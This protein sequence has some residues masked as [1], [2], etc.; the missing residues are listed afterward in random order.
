[1]VIVE[2]G[3]NRLVRYDPKTKTLKAFLNLENKTGKL[4]VDGITLA[5]EGNKPA[6]III[7]DSPNG[8]LLRASLD[9][10]TVT[11]I[12]HGFVRPTGVYVETDGSLLVVDEDGGTLSQL[13]TDGKIELIAHLPT[14]DDV[15]ENSAGDLFVNTLGDGAIH[16][17]KAGTKRDEILI[18][19]LSSPQGLILDADGNL[20]VTDPG[21][22]QLVKIVI[23]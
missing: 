6:G 4:G 19:G 10:Q 2:Q 18:K 13:H 5:V 1:M 12:S 21:H 16:M 14:P 11:E 3:A 23:H 17:F 7:P 9:G 20:I 22:H 15:A 8:R